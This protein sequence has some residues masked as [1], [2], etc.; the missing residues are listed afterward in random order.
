MNIYDAAH[1][2]NVALVGH[3]GCGKTTLAEAMLYTSG[4]LRRMGSVEEQNTVSDYHPSEHERQMSVFTSLL[5]AEWKGHKINILDTPGYPDFMGEVIAALKVADTAM[6]VMNAAEGVQVGTELSWTYGEMTDTPSMFVINHLDRA[7]SDFRI[8]VEQMRE[9]FGRGATIVQI[10]GGAGTRA[11]IDVLLMKQIRFPADQDGQ[12]VFEDIPEEF[13]EEA[14]ALHNELVENVAENDE[15]LM[16]LYFEQGTLTEDEMRQGLRDAMLKRDLFPIFVTSATENVGVAR[17]MSFIDN[18]CPSPTDM[19]AADTET[20]TPV[21]ADPEA[22]PVVF[23]YRTMAEQHVGD[24]SFF[25]LYAGTIAQGLDLVNQQ[26]GSSERLGQLFAINGHE[27]DSVNQ[28]VAGDLGALVKLKNTHTNETLHLKG[29]DVAIS[30]IEFPE[31]RYNAAIRAAKEGEEDKLAQGFHQLAAEDPSLVL[32][33][34]PHLKQTV[35][36]GQ[37]E[38]HLQIARYRL[39]NRFGVDVEYVRPRVAY[40]ETVQERARSSYRHKKQTG[41]AGQFADIS[42]LVE[43]LD[44]DFVAPADINVRKEHSVTTDWGSTIHFIDAIVGGVIDMRRFFGAI[45]KGIFEALQ[46]GPIAGYPVGDV[47]VV[48]FDGGMHSVDSNEAAFKTAARMCFRDAFRN[49]SPALLEPIHD[50]GITVP[51]TF[52]GDVMG[53]LNTRR[54][55]IQGIEAEGIFQKILAQVPE[56]E[57]Y[58]YSTILRSMTQGRGLHRTQFSHY[59]AMPRHV[60]EKVVSENED[61]VEA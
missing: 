38:M 15:A 45:Q 42:M 29:A 18:V 57:L 47:R 27:R 5:H 25:R 10:P 50:V 30:P 40:R 48:I 7:D 12:P 53:D 51:D 2:R 56:A 8:L 31:P 22:D 34:D 1:I 4:G 23:V 37:G 26:T 52:T 3:Q 60:Q 59:E 49:A 21:L 19:P 6:Y 13:R 11:I 41:G 54:G 33:Q 16:E 36:S 39:N 43:P 14:E 9:R 28:M 44:G 17:L 32:K 35:L 58:R 46:D 55:R 20:G 24:Y 61:L